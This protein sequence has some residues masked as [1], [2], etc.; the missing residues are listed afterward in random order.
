MFTVPAALAF[1]AFVI[2]VAALASLMAAAFLYWPAC[3]TPV[4]MDPMAVAAVAAI[5][6]VGS[7]MQFTHRY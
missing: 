7:H 5:I 2:A 6:K 1:A 4:Y 3:A